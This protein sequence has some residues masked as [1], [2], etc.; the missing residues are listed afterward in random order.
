M[1]PVIKYS[2]MV[3]W[4]VSIIQTGLSTAFSHLNGR[5]GWLVTSIVIN[6]WLTAVL[7]TSSLK[8]IFLFL[9]LLTLDFYLIL[10]E[11][12]KD[13]LCTMVLWTK[14]ITK[15]MLMRRKCDAS[16]V[17]T[18]FSFLWKCLIIE[19]LINMFTFSFFST[20]QC[21]RFSWIFLKKRCS[22]LSEDLWK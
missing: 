20:L 16:C 6:R 4:R 2:E 15:C 14:Y 7:L 12:M 22:S 21:E 17:F 10:L 5:G 18:L 13:Q 9:T 8:F 3:K 1:F 11:L 19:E